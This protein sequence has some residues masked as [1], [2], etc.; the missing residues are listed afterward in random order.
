M[1]SSVKRIVKDYLMRLQIKNDKS[2]ITNV[3]I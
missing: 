2:Q 1:L 3:N